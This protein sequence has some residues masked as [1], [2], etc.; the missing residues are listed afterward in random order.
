MNI[1]VSKTKFNDVLI[2]EPEKF[3]DDRGYFI[4]SYSKI[5]YEN[6][7]PSVNFIQDNESKSKYGVLRGLHFQL[8]PFEQSKLVRVIK[9][10]IQDIIV[11]IRK[12]SPTYL[13]HISIILNE[14]NKKQLFVPKGFA[15]GFLVLSQEAV[16]TYKVDNFFNPD[17]DSGI[18]YNDKTLNI[19]WKIDNNK[20]ITSNKDK[21]LPTII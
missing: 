6:F 20:I 21:S 10:E 1:K 11:D 5:K 16:V 7:L 19:N 8:P 3:L 9:G 13:Q 14:D 15:H 12:K 17:Y 2:F 18:I 4:E